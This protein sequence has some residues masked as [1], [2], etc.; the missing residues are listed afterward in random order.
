MDNS[1]R[2]VQSHTPIDTIRSK[3]TLKLGL[4]LKFNSLAIIIGLIY[5]RQK[6]ST[7]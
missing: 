1:T 3:K 4:F 6:W 5:F 7:N 2:Y